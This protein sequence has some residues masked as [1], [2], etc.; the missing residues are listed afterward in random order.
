M[1]QRGFFEMRIGPG[2]FTSPESKVRLALVVLKKR[3][4]GQVIF[5]LVAI[6]VDTVHGLDP[7]AHELFGQ[8]GDLFVLTDDLPV[9]Y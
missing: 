3:H 5:E 1:D 9:E 4:P 7:N 2:V 8:L 6:D